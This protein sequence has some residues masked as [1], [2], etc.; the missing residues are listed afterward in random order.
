MSN[1][2]DSAPRV[3]GAQT[4]SRALDLLQRVA[5][6]HPTGITIGALAEGAELDRATAYRLMSSLVDAGFVERDGHKV[7]RLGLQ[8]M[9]LGLAA[10]TRA[11]LLDACKPL[12]QRLARRT[13]D[14]VFLVVR[15]GDY[16]HCLHCEEGVFPVKALVLQIGGMR[17]LGIGSAGMTLLSRLTDAQIESLY[18]RHVAEFEPHG[19]SLSQLRKLVA[20]TRKQGCAMTDSLVTEGVG[21]VGMSFEISTGGHA[22]ISIAAISSRMRLQRKL[23]IS[24]LIAEEL[25]G[26]GF[27]PA[28]GAQ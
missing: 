19:P 3:K 1:P 11:P 20:Q 10:M 18:Q 27:A 4:V 2:N 25:R 24:R 16:A 28:S 23:E 13:E 22:A 21:G 7:Y 6:I 9:Q 17:V 14:T 15:N 12:M 26:A 8:A 5:G